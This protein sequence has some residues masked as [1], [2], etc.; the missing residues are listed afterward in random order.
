MKKAWFTLRQG[1]A[2]FHK[3]VCLWL[4]LMLPGIIGICLIGAILES[5]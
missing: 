4:Y 5:I 3:M 2:P 1:E